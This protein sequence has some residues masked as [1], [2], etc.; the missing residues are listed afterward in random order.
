MANFI[1]NPESVSFAQ[2]KRNLLTYIATLPSYQQYSKFYRS[3]GG[4][5][6]VS[7]IAGLATYD[8]YTGIASTRENYLGYTNN[9]V[10]AIGITSNTSYNAYR[11][12][13]VIIQLRVIPDRNMIIRKYETCGSINGVDISP[14]TTYT[15]LQ[16]VPI[17][18]QCVVG[19]VIT[20]TQVARDSN[21]AVFVF[22]DNRVSQDLKYLLNNEEVPICLDAKSMLNDEYYLQSNAFGGVSAHY[23]NYNIPG[24][25]PL[26]PYTTGDVFSLVYVK[27]QNIQFN[28]TTDVLFDYG[29]LDFSHVDSLVLAPYRSP[30]SKESIQINAPISFETQKTI[31]GREDFA[32]FFKTLNSDFID[33]SSIDVALPV[34]YLGQKRVIP[35]FTDITYV[36]KDLSLLLPSEVASLEEQINIT[37]KARPH[38]IPPSEIRHPKGIA[39]ELQ[40]RLTQKPL[41]DNATYVA[42][43]QNIFNVYLD[44]KGFTQ[45]RSGKLQY[46]I[47]LKDLEYDLERLPYVLV[48]RVNIVTKTWQP[49]HLYKRGDFL[50]PTVANGFMYEVISDTFTYNSLANTMDNVGVLS[51]SVEPTW[52]TLEDRYNFDSVPV[53]QSSHSYSVG[54]IIQPTTVNNNSYICRTAGTTGLFEPTFG[55]IV[56]EIFY[57]DTVSWQVLNPNENAS[58]TYRAHNINEFE[59]KGFWREYYL[60]NYGAGVVWQ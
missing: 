23:L 31:R 5:H 7:L 48:A 29:T 6:I 14:L 43:I 37:E 36:K 1:I 25:S 33:T 24:G 30:E 57:D 18:I 60:F 39:L 59:F 42:D 56:N 35:A 47:S 4:D 16:N 38:G 15:L 10:N 51:G 27:L 20:S 13:N 58:L 44:S 21:L 53:W 54:D 46:T 41:T 28:F 32:K 55:T 45:I 34:I 26:Y 17:T 40:I 12:R 22:T 52:D 3:E 2:I 50:V 8:R 19:D 11:G 49:N 9:R